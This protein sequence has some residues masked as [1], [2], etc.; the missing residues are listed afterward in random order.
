MARNKHPEETVNLILEVAFRLFTEKGY[1]HTS[2]QEI[3]DHLGGLSKGAIYHHFKSK[4]EILAAVTDK[5]TEDSNQILAAIRDCKDLNG[6]EKLKTIFKESIFRPVQD[7]IFATAPNIG[8]SPQLMFSIIRD[9]IDEVAPRYIQPIVEQGIA[10]GSIQTDYP[11]ELAELII[12]VANF[13]MNPML[14]SD[15]PEASYRKIMVYQQ[16]LSG[17]GLDIL[18]DELVNRLKELIAIYQQNK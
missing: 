3:I 15:S 5:M 10:D 17:F 9:T 2:I 1:E 16:M 4:E 7:E 6:K 14:F 12:L 18:D 13:W 11:A 8:K